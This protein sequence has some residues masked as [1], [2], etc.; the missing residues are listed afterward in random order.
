MVKSMLQIGN[1][2][3]LN[4]GDKYLYNCSIRALIN[5]N[6]KSSLNI[7]DYFNDLKF[8]GTECSEYDVEKVYKDYTCQELIWERKELN[9]FEIMFLS[10][11]NPIYTHIV[12]YNDKEIGL[13]NKKDIYHIIGRKQNMFKNKMFEKFEKCKFYEIKEVLKN[14]NL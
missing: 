5:L 10:N 7:G 6:G 11:L 14:G 13:S 9:Q 12:I 1:V 3:Q 2:V 8:I 4:N